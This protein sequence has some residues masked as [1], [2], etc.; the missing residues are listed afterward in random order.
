MND[1]KK[2]KTKRERDSGLGHLIFWIQKK[3]IFSWALLQVD[4]IYSKLSHVLQKCINT[5]G[6]FISLKS[7]KST[8]EKLYMYKYTQNINDV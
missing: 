2:K 1:L 3:I 7:V 5:C 6:R 4:R 8:A